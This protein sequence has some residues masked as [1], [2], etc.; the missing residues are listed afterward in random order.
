M[1]N[2]H[3]S[4]SFQFVVNGALIESDISESL[5]FP[6]VQEELSVDGCARTFFLENRGIESA[7]IHSL[8]LLL[9]GETIHVRRSQGLLSKLFESGHSHESVGFGD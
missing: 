3:L 9:S 1:R 2:I 5:T 4:E 7:D 6:A 8:Q